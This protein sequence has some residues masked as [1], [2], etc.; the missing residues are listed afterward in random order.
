MNVRD[1]ASA[2]TGSADTPSDVRTIKRVIVAVLF[3][4]VLGICYIAQAVL[5][6]LTLAL[7]LSL[8]LS[9]LV[10]LLQ[11]LRM[12]RAVGS[13]LILAVV[14]AA[15]AGGV[16]MLAQPARDWM[17][18][19]PQYIQAI[20]RR[21]ESVRASIDAAQVA[22]KKIENLG[23]STS[24]KTPTVVAAQQPGLLASA[25]T[26]TPRV[27]TAV[28][29][30]LLLVY[31]FLSSGNGFLRRM[32]EVAPGMSE[33][34]MVVH[35]AREVQEEMSRYLL[36]VSAI[37]L[38]LG[39]ATALAMFLLGVPNPLLWGVVAAVLNFA[40]YVG[41]AMT[42]IGLL[43]VGITTFDTLGHALAV[44]GAFFALAIV[45]GQLVTPT[46]IGRRLSLD[47]AVVFVWLL[48]WGS[49]WGIVGILLAGPLIACFRIVCQHVEALKSVGILIGDGSI[50]DAPGKK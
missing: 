38:V 48:L 29:E 22:T 47:P 6:P 26:V 50:A 16:T 31:F 5:I 24:A 20:Q 14:V 45:E 3:F 42:G 30:V 7:L 41:P 13:I 2:Q 21:F 1:D 10:T 8:L 11:R 36:M 39:A 25:A 12:P 27:L 17:A 4:L 34:K 15:I 32:V 28:A 40:P 37:N 33:K 9:P 44:P 35:I 18:H 46:I 19:A 49:L 23:Q 43:L